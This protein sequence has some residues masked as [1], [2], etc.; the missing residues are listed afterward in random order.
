ML[1]DKFNPQ[2]AE[3]RLYKMWE[4]SGAFKPRPAK[5]GDTAEDNFSIVIPRPM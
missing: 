2:E 4:D 3:P 1:D 5:Q